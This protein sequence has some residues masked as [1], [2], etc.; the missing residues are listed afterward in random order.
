ML[1]I[2]EFPFL[3]CNSS[4]LFKWIKGVSFWKSVVLR[5]WRSSRGKCGL[6]NWVD[7]VKRFKVRALAVQQK[8]STKIWRKLIFTWFNTNHFI[9]APSCLL[10]LVTQQIQYLCLFQKRATAEAVLRQAGDVTNRT[11]TFLTTECPGKLSHRCCSPWWKSVV[12]SVTNFLKQ[13]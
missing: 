10:K 6:T 3:F 1:L 2:G 13:F 8:T 12:E 7:D 5:R 11:R 9:S 4:I